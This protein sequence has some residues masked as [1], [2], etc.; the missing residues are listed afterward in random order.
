MENMHYETNGFKFFC[1]KIILFIG[2]G[3]YDRLRLQTALN[4]NCIFHKLF[5][6]PD[7]SGIKMVYSFFL[8]LA[9]FTQCTVVFLKLIN[10]D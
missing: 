10:A 2:A 6:V 3:R 5:E 1:S 4:F 7:M 9:I 8:C